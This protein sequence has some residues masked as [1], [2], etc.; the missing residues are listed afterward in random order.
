ML[1]VSLILLAI[2]ALV[3]HILFGYYLDSP[4]NPP[5]RYFRPVVATLVIVVV[6][7]LWFVLPLHVG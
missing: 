2:I 7:I 3:L 4:P 1:P 6:L 5:N